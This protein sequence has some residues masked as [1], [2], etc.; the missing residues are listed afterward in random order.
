[1]I[2]DII[3]LFPEMF[4]GPFDQSIVKR[5][6]NQKLVQ[7]N[8]RN[9]RHW[10]SDKRGTVDNKPY[11]GGTGMILMIEP[12]VKALDALRKKN[13]KVILTSPSGKRFDQK[14]ASKLVKEK[15][16]IIICGHY[17]GMDERVK[18]FINE[19]V[20]VGDY[21][22]TGGELPAMVMIDALV[23]LLPGVL[24]KTEATQ[25]ESFSS[26]TLDAKSYSLLEYPQYTRPANFQGLKVP[27]VLLSG[28]HQQIST[29]RQRQALK[30]T[31]LLR[32]DL[33]K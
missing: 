14:L 31:H 18:N 19:E 24:K 13:T 33:L 21:I 26:Y 8:F 9:L 22:L 30:K 17:E 20:S 2:I 15:H 11:G 4:Q 32:P 28:N 27:K 1:M 29:W 16:L 12:L 25:S 7:I 5:A 10:A 23:R 6:Q 3:T